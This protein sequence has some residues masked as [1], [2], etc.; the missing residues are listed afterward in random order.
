VS[1]VFSMWLIIA[2]CTFW[3]INDYLSIYV[4]G[5]FCNTTHTHTHTLAI[6]INNCMYK[7][8]YIKTTLYGI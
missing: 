7:V 1:D 6:F 2:L 8:M 3:S 4:Q 5:H